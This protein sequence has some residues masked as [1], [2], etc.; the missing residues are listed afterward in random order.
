MPPLP[1]A[2]ETAAPATTGTEVDRPE[3]AVCNQCGA[4]LGWFTG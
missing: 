2:L 1:C 3:E 4:A